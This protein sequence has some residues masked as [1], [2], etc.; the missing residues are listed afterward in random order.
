MNTP[1]IGYNA[2]R[3]QIHKPQLFKFWMGVTD[4]GETSFEVYL[5]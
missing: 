3:E 2:N 5:E 1:S 4:V